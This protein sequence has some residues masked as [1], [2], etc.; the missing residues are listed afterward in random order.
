MHLLLMLALNAEP[1]T[2][3]RRPKLSRLLVLLLLLV[4]SL[5]AVEKSRGASALE[6]W[7]QEMAVKGDT[8][9]AAKLWPAISP[10]SVAFTNRLN[11]VM[12]RLPREW[13]NYGGQMTVIVADSPG[14][15]RR[16][17]QEPQPVFWYP[18][19]DTNTWENL[20]ALVPQA[21]PAL[22]SLRALM[23]NPPTGV[24]YIITNSFEGGSF[25]N[26]VKIRQ[27]AQALAGAAMNDLH[28]NNLDGALENLVALNGFVKLYAD[29]PSLVA[30]MIR[31]AIMS[32][33]TDLIWDA[34]QADGWTDARLVK[35]QESCYDTKTF[36]S[37]MPR[38]FEGTR[39]ARLH[40]LH[41]LKS[42]TFQAYMDRAQASVAKFG[43]TIAP[44]SPWRQWCFHP[45]WRVAW[46]DDEELEYLKQTEPELEALRAA[47]KGQSLKRLSQQVAAI[48]EGY[49]PPTNAWRFYGKLPSLEIVYG[50]PTKTSEPEPA[51]PYTDCRRAWSVVMGNLTRNEMALTAIA[52]KRY[53]LRY[54]KSPTSLEALVP[55]F[56]KAMPRDLMDGQPLRCRLMPEQTFAIYSVGNDFIDDGGN[57]MS[58]LAAGPRGAGYDSPWYGIDWVWCPGVAAGKILKATARDASEK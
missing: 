43:G 56:L 28:E 19:G 30:Y 49:R 47:T 20:K 27:G 25:P 55:D 6:K 36:L 22:Q 13:W 37:Q 39:T 50:P 8:F 32:L 5:L 40:E 58:K 16:G 38:A 1:E 24:P 34:L 35:L 4:G 2:P 48:H 15:W 57:P 18:R 46:A 9:E 51:Y 3:L 31:A 10:E 26:F 52:V 7:K 53:E 23:Q 11:E 17:S 45:V 14:H 44:Q 42:H 33:G 12:Q 54:G 41:W 29:D 21:E